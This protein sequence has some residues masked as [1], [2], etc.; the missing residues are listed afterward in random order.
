MAKVHDMDL[1]QAREDFVVE[2]VRAP[3]KDEKVDISESRVSHTSADLRRSLIRRRARPTSSRRRSGAALR[4]L[5]HHATAAS[6]SAS[7][8]GAIVT[9][10]DASR[11]M[12]AIRMGQ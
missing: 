4:W 7:A 6:I 2:D 11:D 5:R 1:P 8:S 3:A 9:E 10:N 12:E